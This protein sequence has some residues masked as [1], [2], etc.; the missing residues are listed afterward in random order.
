MRDYT[1]TV[2]FEKDEEGR[3]L[4]I[5]PALQGCYADGETREEAEANI[6]E[7]IEAH[8]ASRLKHDEPIYSE[9]G[10]Q[11]MVVAV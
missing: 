2:V 1:F 11:Q 6:R 5:C 10:A 9:V 3:I 8:V 4:A 7:A